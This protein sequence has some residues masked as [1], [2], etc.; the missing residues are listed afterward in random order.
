M[1]DEKRLKQIRT[2]Y[3]QLADELKTLLID[4]VKQSGDDKIKLS[5][6]VEMPVIVNYFKLQE[7]EQGLKK[8]P[9]Q[10]IELAKIES[11][12]LG[13]DDSDDDNKTIVYYPLFIDQYNHEFDEDDI[14]GNIVTAFTLLDMTGAIKNLIKK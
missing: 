6:T 11:I 8:I 13:I 3:Q 2:D 4:I 5:K 12:A 14:Y 1:F 9:D 7:T 10:R